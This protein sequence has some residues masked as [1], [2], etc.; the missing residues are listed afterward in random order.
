MKSKSFIILLLL[1]IASGVKSQDKTD[2][3]LFGDVKSAATKEHI[4]YANILVKGTKLGTS[5]DATGHFK[6]ANLPLGKLTII[7]SAVGYKPQEIEVV[8]EK[9]K[10]INVFFE[11][12]ED[13]LNLGQ[14][15][16]TGTRTEH[17]IKDVPVRTQV[18]TSKEIEN[19]N[20]S[21]LYEALEGTP[22][23]IVEQQCQYCNISMVRMQGLGA[24]HTQVLID[25]QPIY[26]GLA[27]VYGLQ[28]I[29]TV[30]IDQIEIVKGAGSA[31]YGS[32]AIAGSINIITKEPS[33][34]PSTNIDV[35]FGSY[36]TNRYQLSSSIKNENGNLGLTINA[37]KLVAD[38]I[39]ETGPGLTRSEVLKKDG[40]TDRVGT[41]LTNLGFGLF[42][43]NLLS[44]DD[45]LTLRGKSIFENRRGGILTNDYFKNPFSEG[46]ENITTKRYETHLNYKKPIGVKSGLD[47]SISYA[48][49]NREATNDTYLKDYMATHNNNPPNV[50]DMRPYIARENTL[51]STVTFNSTLKNHNLLFGVQ[52]YYDK[53]NET[54]MYVVI[55]STSKYF[56]QSYKSIAN[57][58]ALEIG[59][60]LQDEWSVT[61]KLMIVPGVRIDKHHSEE[62]YN[63]DRTVFDNNFPKSSFNQ[64]SVNPRLAIKY[65]VSRFL[66]IRAN[67]GTGF[68]APYGFSEDLHLCS[69]SPR[70][71]KS[72]A[73]KPETAIS[74]NFSSDYYGNNFS[75][76]ANL[77]HT[78]L[79]NKIGFTNADPDIAALGYDYQWKNFD[80]AFVQGVELY[81]QTKLINNINV[82][83][84]FTFNNGKYKN[85][86]QD[87]IDT[88][89][90]NIS[91]NIQR[92]PSTTGNL[93]IEYNPTTWR[94]NLTGSYQGSMC[95]DY[96]S[97]DP[98]K[99][100]I[101]KTDPYMIFNFRV[102]KSI[103][104][105][106]V[107]AGVD[108][109]FNYIQ[110]ERYLD[111]AAFMYAP[112]YGRMFYG[113]IAIDIKH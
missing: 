24:E 87:W 34:T 14:V 52:F 90:E 56:G 25:G 48:N 15:V 60:F 5:A 22:G 85:A 38:E 63:S 37:E 26:S 103:N 82:G 65:D 9:N 112:I 89:Y 84:S 12:E 57:K 68:R 32:N 19:K 54:G 21:T 80:D 66:V 58:S 75:I 49:H 4:P 93:S 64:I 31:L 61:D 17:F 91:K 62:V 40:I 104:N 71:W 42:A 72:S 30:D 8:M 18:I 101:Q 53:L 106:K 2:A 74:Y 23:V 33:F 95:I 81:T 67:V 69:G 86:R 43:Y 76:G 102:S 51:T 83:I 111:D 92:L 50:L 1:I 39:D 35:Q 6:L 97:E 41:D 16:V 109:I 79:K 7:A 28:Q 13:I 105:F 47:I 110:R 107:Y 46:T 77:F 73:L 100:K 78:N 59:A 99:S 108:N 20:A 70:V 94:I 98:N 44:D 10:A 45:K 11:L 55:D 3:M 88:E 96:Y 29:G 27:G 36:N 113:G